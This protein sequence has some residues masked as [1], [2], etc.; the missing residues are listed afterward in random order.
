MVLLTQKLLITLA[1]FVDTTSLQCFNQP[2]IEN[3]DTQINV[4]LQ[5]QFSIP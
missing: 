4:Q 2:T 3:H 1:L 5:I